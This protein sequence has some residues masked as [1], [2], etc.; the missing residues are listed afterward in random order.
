MPLSVRHVYV[1][2]CDV[3]RSEYADP[4]TE[5]IA[6]FEDETSA[7]QIVHADGWLVLARPRPDRFICRRTDSDHQARM[8]ALM[9]PE[10]V[11]QIPGQLE[12]EG[13]EES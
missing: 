8:D 3:C 2:M 12:L 4:E 13:T 11:M 6:W 5:T 10:P 1:V 7:E 9:P